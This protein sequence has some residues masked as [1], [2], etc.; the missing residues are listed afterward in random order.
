MGW[1]LGNKNLHLTMHV[2]YELRDCATKSYRL[3][4]LKFG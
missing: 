4:M 3:G 1:E 2:L